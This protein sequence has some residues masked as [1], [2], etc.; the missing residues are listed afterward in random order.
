MTQYSLGWELLEMQA[1][2]YFLGYSPVPRSGPV[3]QQTLSEPRE[4]REDGRLEI[5]TALGQ[6][7]AA[8]TTLGIGP[9]QQYLHCLKGLF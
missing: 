4:A 5:F 7:G 3:T 9:S 8:V 1:V 2:S 6:E